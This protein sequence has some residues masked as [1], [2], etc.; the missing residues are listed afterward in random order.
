MQ[1]S[2]GKLTSLYKSGTIIIN[3]HAKVIKGDGSSNRTVVGLNTWFASVDD[4]TMRGSAT[5]VTTE[6]SAVIAV[7]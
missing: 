6:T 2:R 5:E 4:A 7:S 3:S 1:T